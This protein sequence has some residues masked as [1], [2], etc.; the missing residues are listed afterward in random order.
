MKILVVDDNFV[1]RKV[2]VKFLE[3][4]G[5]V[6]VAVNGREAMEAIKLGHVEQ[7]PYELILLDI[8]MPEMDGQETLQAIRQYEKEHEIYTSDGVKIIMV[9]ALSDSKNIMHAFRYGCENYITKPVDRSKLLEAVR[10][11]GFEMPS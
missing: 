8:M 6:D 7:N 4:L 1:N 9:T 10:N 5:E 11:L 2:L 3:H